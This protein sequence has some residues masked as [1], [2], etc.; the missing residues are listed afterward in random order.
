MWTRIWGSA[1]FSQ[2]C[3]S[4]KGRLLPEVLRAP[5]ALHPDQGLGM[6]VPLGYQANA[7]PSLTSGYRRVFYSRDCFDHCCLGAGG[8]QDGPETRQRRQTG[9]GGSRPCSP[10]GEEEPVNRPGFDAAIFC[11]KD[12]DYA[13][14]VPSR[15]P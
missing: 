11:E 10:A 9:N 2:V 7:G 8:E 14:A 6:F 12:S 13:Q 5:D 15:G 3:A 4:P 1:W